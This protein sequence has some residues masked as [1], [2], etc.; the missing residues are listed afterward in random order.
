MHAQAY[1]IIIV[2]GGL[3]GTLMA[4]RL[5]DQDAEL[6]LLLLEA[7]PTLGG[8]HTWC[9]HASDLSRAQLE[10]IRP[11]VAHDWPSQAVQ[12]P[13]Y[14]RELATAYFALS[15][16][17]LHELV[18]RELGATVRFNQRVR[19]VHA[20]SVE[21]DDGQCLRANSVF[22][23]RG[24]SAELP[25]AL[26]YQSFL[27]REL[28]LEAPH[29]I[30]RPVIMD[31]TVEQLGGYRFVYL[32]PFDERRLLVEDTYYA[33]S[34]DLDRRAIGRRIDDYVYRKGWRI[35]AVDREEVGVLP[36]TLAGDL[37]ALWRNLRAGPVPLGMRAGLFHPT[38]GYSIGHVLRLNE[39]IAQHIGESH[40]SRFTRVEGY[41]RHAWREQ[42]YFRRLNRML[43]IGASG[44][45][46]RAVFE[47]FYRLPTGLIE[48][49]YAERLTALDKLRILTGRPP[50]GIHKALYALTSPLPLAGAANDGI[51]RR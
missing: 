11:L 17:R 29:G 48:R 5:R 27:G 45:Q 46:R 2:G 44:A 32:L 36:I 22:D 12:F 3:A 49:F 25:L 37:D 50:I 40:E 28:R 16:T 19:E 42:R 1:D 33:D 41:A 34:P 20:Q 13:A 8:N 38:T 26:G 9:F 6:S 10:W 4:L 14:E 30:S 15:S 35:A 7:G 47:R 31:A 18:S 51:A 23:A 21:L 43:F 39:L 24:A